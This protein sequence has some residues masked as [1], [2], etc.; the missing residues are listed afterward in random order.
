MAKA[1]I[2][3]LMWLLL[4]KVA[5][6]AGVTAALAFIGL[7]VVLGIVLVVAGKGRRHN[8]PQRPIEEGV[9]MPVSPVVHHVVHH[10]P[11]PGW[12]PPYAPAVS[13]SAVH[14]ARRDAGSDRLPPWAWP[15]NN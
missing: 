11:G 3:L 15:S 5:K 12:L 2:Y 13:S 10:V 1:V 6:Y 7:M 8:E 14:P 4:P 9:A